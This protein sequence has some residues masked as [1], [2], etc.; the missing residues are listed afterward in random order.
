MHRGHYDAVKGPCQDTAAMFVG[1]TL[2]WHRR[3]INMSHYGVNSYCI[4]LW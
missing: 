1:V 4:D 2:N 3:K